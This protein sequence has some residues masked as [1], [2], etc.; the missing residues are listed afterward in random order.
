LDEDKSNKIPGK[1]KD[2][3]DSLEELDKHIKKNE[4]KWQSMVK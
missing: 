3:G 4:E 2:T 1:G